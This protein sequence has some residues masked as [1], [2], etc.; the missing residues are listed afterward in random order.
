MELDVSGLRPAR[1]RR[2]YGGGERPYCTGG[3]K[4]RADL[5]FDIGVAA[6]LPRLRSNRP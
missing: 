4:T 1:P 2:L 5:A 3:R 6:A